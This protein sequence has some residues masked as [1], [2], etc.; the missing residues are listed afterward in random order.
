MQDAAA[1]AGILALDGF[2]IKEVRKS[3]QRCRQGCRQRCRDL[4]G[5]A[6]FPLQHHPASILTELPHAR[7]G[8]LGS[9]NIWGIYRAVSFPVPILSRRRAGTCISDVSAPRGELQP[10]PGSAPAPLPQPPRLPRG[11]RSSGCRWL[12]SAS[13]PFPPSRAASSLP[14]PSFPPRIFFYG[15]N[16]MEK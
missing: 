5:A 12:P 7:H 8:A 16:E 1:A 13:Q 9:R 2:P 10:G 3:R 4:G 14:P 15:R 11:G 6:A